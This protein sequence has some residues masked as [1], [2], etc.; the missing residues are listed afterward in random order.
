M[1]YKD[2]DQVVILQDGCGPT[3]HSFEPNSKLIKNKENDF[4][5]LYC[6]S[7]REIKAGEEICE[8]YVD[9]V[10]SS[11]NWA[12]DLFRKYVPSRLDFER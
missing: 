4:F 1:Y 6:V 8:D 11:N 2:G 10:K 3:N 5:K 7:T 9:Y 12:E